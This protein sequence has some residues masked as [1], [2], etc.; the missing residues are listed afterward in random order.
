MDKNELV[1]KIRGIEGLTNDEKSALIQLLRKQ[2]KYGLVWEDKPEDVEE[3]LREELPVLIEDT[4]KAI[5]STNADAPNHI[6][7]EGDNL[8][9]LTALAYTHEGKIDV[10]YIDPPYNTGNKD[11][12]YNDKYIDKEDSYR[13]SKWLSFM[14]KRLRIAKQLLSDEGAIFISIDDNEQAQLKM[15][16]DEV[17]NGNL[18]QQFIIESNPRGSQSSKYFANTHEYLLC[19]SKTPNPNIDFGIN[20]TEENLSEYSYEDNKGKYRLL[21]LRQRGG[22]WR[23]ADRPLLFY[24]FYVNPQNGDISLYE[25]LLHSIKVLPCRPTGEESRWTWSKEKVKKES[26]FLIGAIVNKGTEN[27]KWDIFRKNYLVNEKGEVR[28]SKVKSIWNEK[29]INYQNG[30]AELKNI[31]NAEKFS[32]PKP[33]FL[34]TKILS[35][36]TREDSTILDFF[37]G[38]GTTLHATLQLNSEDGG[39]R[40]C[41]LVTNNENKICEEVTYVRNKQVIQGYTTPKGEKV[42]GLTGNTLRYYKTDFISRDRT[43][44]NM[45]ALVAAS[46]DLLCIKNDIYKEAK[47]AGRN[48]N[49]KIARYFEEGDSRMLIIYDERAISA[50]AEI[51]EMVESRKEKIKVY[52]FSPSSYA[53]DDEFEEVADKVQ[54]C[55]LPDAIYQAYQKVL[56]KR[57]PKFLPEAMEEAEQSNDSETRLF[58]SEA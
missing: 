58:M 32:Y 11:F 41:I 56:P 16:C 29:E 36:S 43:P 1:N 45:R 15:L 24:P 20:K 5:I 21:G 12:I 6:L 55:A 38:S 30:G 40:K 46:T 18:L 13:H 42:P 57:R 23:R 51:L 47:L 9:A 2:K 27:E 4:D 25:D 31:I 54:L 19:Y 50:I 53:Y 39:G 33:L 7:I 44:R 52:V 37:A 8:E 34:L 26:S 3:R 48:I 14:S 35:I 49:S 28:K 22:A 10:I 17:F